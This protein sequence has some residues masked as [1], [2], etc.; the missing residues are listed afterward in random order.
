MRESSLVFFL[1]SGDRLHSMATVVL[2]SSKLTMDFPASLPP[3]H[4]APFKHRIYAKPIILA[5]ILGRLIQHNSVLDPTINNLSSPWNLNSSWLNI[6][7][8]HI[9][10]MDLGLLFCWTLGRCLNEFLNGQGQQLY[11]VFNAIPVFLTK[12]AK[13]RGWR[14]EGILWVELK[15]RLRISQEWV[16]RETMHG[17][18]FPWEIQWT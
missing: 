2:S 12:Q 3:L 1:S 16:A 13:K 10:G 17:G 15:E 8:S 7:C 18:S 6:I 4:A 5:V 9:L 14:A 11:C